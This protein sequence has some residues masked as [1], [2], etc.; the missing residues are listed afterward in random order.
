[1]I[2]EAQL[3]DVDP[4]NIFD[5]LKRSLEE[6]DTLSMRY[7]KGF[8]PLPHFLPGTTE[9]QLHEMQSEA[10]SS[11]IP[12]LQLAGQY[13]LR[14]YATLFAILNAVTDLLNTRQNLSL[15]HI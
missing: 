13:L 14:T 15:I 11:C 4:I 10:L 8:I 2:P 7:V 3:S 12:C 9:T 1:M 5:L 6:C